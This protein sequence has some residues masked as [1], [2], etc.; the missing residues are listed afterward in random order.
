[1]ATTAFGAAFGIT[2]TGAATGAGAGAGVEALCLAK[3]LAMIEE[4]LADPVA[5]AT[6]V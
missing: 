1:M 5:A 3:T 2:G 4:T 6:E